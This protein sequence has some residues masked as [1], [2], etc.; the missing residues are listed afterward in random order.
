MIVKSLARFHHS[1]ADVTF[2]GRVVLA[3]SKRVSAG[4]FTDIMCVIRLTCGSLKENKMRRS[5]NDAHKESLSIIIFVYIYTCSYNQLHC[6]DDYRKSSE[7]VSTACK[8]TYGHDISKFP[9]KDFKPRS[10]AQVHCTENGLLGHDSPDLRPL[11]SNLTD[12]HINT[13]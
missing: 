12:L 9:T 11:H 13:V 1:F 10:R 6:K 3:R 7:D 8:E 2:K 5:L 4:I